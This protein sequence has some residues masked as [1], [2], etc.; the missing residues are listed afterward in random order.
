MISKYVVF[1][2]PPT[3]LR[4][5]V[6]LIGKFSVAHTFITNAYREIYQSCDNAI[7]FTTSQYLLT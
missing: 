4:L 3:A 6:R 1:K 7:T 5:L 2:A